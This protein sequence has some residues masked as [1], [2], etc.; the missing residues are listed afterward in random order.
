MVRCPYPWSVV[1]IQGPKS[2]VRRPRSVV[3]ADLSSISPVK[4][5]QSVS[6]RDARQRHSA[7]IYFD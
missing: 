5:G 2:V 4:K 3:L 1:R 7:L 6:L